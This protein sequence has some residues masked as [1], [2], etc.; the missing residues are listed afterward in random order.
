M[1]PSTFA[2]APKPTLVT[3]SLSPRKVTGRVARVQATP[4]SVKPKTST[5]T[6]P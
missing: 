6:A 2:R 1:K 3:Q 5:G 4:V